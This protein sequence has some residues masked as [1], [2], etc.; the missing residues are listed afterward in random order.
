[1]LYYK[2]ITY[3]V[4]GK[5]YRTLKK[6]YSN[7]MSCVNINGN[8]SDWFYTTNGCRQGDVTSPTAFCVLI[9]DL[10][11]E[12]KDSNIGI[13]LDNLIVSVLAYADDIVLLADSPENLQKLINIVQNWCTK[14]RL[15]IN[16]GKSKVVHFRNPPK[17]RTSFEFKLCDNG[18]ELEIVDKYKYLGLFV[19]EFLTFKGAAEILSSAAGWALGGMINKY[20]YLKEM[21]YKTYTKLYENLVC[22]VMDYA[23]A[24]WGTKSFDCMESVHRRAIRFFVGVHRLSPIPGYIGDMGWY[25]NRIRWK[26]E[27]VRLWNRLINTDNNRLVKKIFL[28]DINAHSVHNKSNF[29]AQVKQI[30]CDVNLKECFTNKT[31][32]DLTTVRNVLFQKFSQEWLDS[33]RNMSK[34][35]IYC[36]VKSDLKVEKYLEL[37]ISKYEKSLLSQLRYGILPLRVETGRFVNERREDRICKLCNLNQVEDQLHFVFHCPLYAGNREELYRKARLSIQTWD[38]LSD[39]DKLCQLF[40]EVP[41]N[42]GKYVKNSFVLRR[43]TIFK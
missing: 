14:W 33:T 9:N 30:C 41:R 19:D 3:G 4:D 27:M 39:I 2:L 35:D 6:M 5:M 21:N 38:Q 13:K 37:N 22:P 28:Y 18:P 40:T 20:K 16:P 34:L 29:S 17:Q 43:Q 42:L 23:S 1:M 32:I 10:I 12:L 31:N 26:I 24:I 25:S 7:T 11:K 8:L 36:N 15:I